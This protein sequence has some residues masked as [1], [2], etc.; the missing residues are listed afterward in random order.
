LHTIEFSR[1]FFSK[2]TSLQ[3]DII[4]L[5]KIPQMSGY[6]SLDFPVVE[7]SN[8]LSLS[9]RKQLRIGIAVAITTAILLTFYFYN[10]VFF[11]II[12]IYFGVCI[13]TAVL[14]FGAAILYPLL[15]DVYYRI[16][17]VLRAA[18]CLYLIFT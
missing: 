16:V 5:S 3:Y 12:Y 11:Y 8:K 14:L 13:V 18:G 2:C 4:W 6:A 1:A 17:N 15:V 9:V 7:E 10:T